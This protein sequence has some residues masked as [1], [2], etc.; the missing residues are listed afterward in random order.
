MKIVSYSIWKCRTTTIGIDHICENC[1]VRH[2]L[3]YCVNRPLPAKTFR[4]GWTPG[5]PRA[6]SAS[7]SSGPA[8]PSGR[9]CCSSAGPTIRKTLWPISSGWTGWAA[10]STAASGTAW[11]PSGRALWGCGRRVS[12]DRSP[13]GVDFENL[14]FGRKNIPIQSE[15]FFT[16]VHQTFYIITCMLQCN[17]NILFILRLN[18]PKKQCLCTFIR[19]D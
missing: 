7:R 4:R 13:P 12:R 8:S 18:G 3:S 17:Y 19:P 6:A 14:Y 5:R 2:N 15:Y 11:A 9:T 1:V 10:P 16:L